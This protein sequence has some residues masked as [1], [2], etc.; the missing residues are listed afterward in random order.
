MD[1]QDLVGDSTPSFN[2]IGGVGAVALPFGL[3]L[4][5][6]AWVYQQRLISFR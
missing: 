4:L 3:L 5:F 6:M 2:I 1:L